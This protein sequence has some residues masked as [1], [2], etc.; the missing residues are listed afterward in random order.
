MSNDTQT[1][2]Q[3]K[4][5]YPKDD[6]CLT[7]TNLITTEGKLSLNQVMQKKNLSKQ[8]A[9]N[10]LKH[11]VRDDILSR[12]AIIQGKGRPTIYYSRTQN[13]IKIPK[14]DTVSITFKKLKILCKNRDR[15]GSCQ[16]KDKEC[17]ILSCPAILK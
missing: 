5:T 11:L 16:E 6:H 13:P 14:E 17:D 1:P 4:N 3:T 8:T 7:I 10:H 12:E 2:T 15:N 9:H